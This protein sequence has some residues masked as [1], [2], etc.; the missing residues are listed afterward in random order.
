MYEVLTYS[1]PSGVELQKVMMCC[2]TMANVPV[3]PFLRLAA[4]DA[5][6]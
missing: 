4:A 1:V 3:R 2:T 5:T 6:Q